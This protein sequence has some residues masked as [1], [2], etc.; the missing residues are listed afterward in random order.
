MIHLVMQPVVLNVGERSICGGQLEGQPCSINYRD[1]AE[2]E[3]T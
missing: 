2:S 1:G 3:Q